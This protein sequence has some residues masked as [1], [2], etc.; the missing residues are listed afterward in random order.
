VIVGTRLD[1]NAR[2]DIERL[3]YAL[4]RDIESRVYFT[5]R[6]ELPVGIDVQIS[7]FLKA[8]KIPEAPVG[9]VRPDLKQVPEIV[10]PN[11]AQNQATGIAV[12]TSR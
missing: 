1:D 9:Y 7:C 10:G 6:F 12:I 2:D 8:V 4:C 11:P 5:A 3:F